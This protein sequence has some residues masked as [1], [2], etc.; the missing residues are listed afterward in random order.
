MEPLDTEAKFLQYVCL[1]RDF[2]NTVDA[3]TFG[4][5]MPRADW[6]F[7]GNM[8]IP[9]PDRQ[10]QSNII[11]FLNN[12]TQRLDALAQAKE[13]L[14]RLLLEMREALVTFAVIR[15]IDPDARLR[16]SSVSWLGRSLRNG[17][18]VALHGF[19]KR[20]ISAV[21]RIFLYWRCRLTP[22]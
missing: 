7:I 14:I 10:Q 16:N 18:S 15:G 12:E 8:E 20:E 13:S 9:V 5:K 21:S 19:F 6:D 1:S 3:S 4:S 2:V 11:Q 17:M 22:A